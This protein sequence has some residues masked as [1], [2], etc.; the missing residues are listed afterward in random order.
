MRRKGGEGEEEV[1]LPG[2]V[3]DLRDLG[4]EGGVGALLEAEQGCGELAGQDGDEI[5]ERW[6]EW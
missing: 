5:A 3:V 2:E 1:D 6:R 4:G